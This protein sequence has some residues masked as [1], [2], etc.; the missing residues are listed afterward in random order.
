MTAFE[1]RNRGKL[2][3]AGIVLTDLFRP[4]PLVEIRPAARPVSLTW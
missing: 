4:V 3:F 2:P 1:V